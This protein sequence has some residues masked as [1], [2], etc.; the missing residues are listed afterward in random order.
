MA[1]IS[2]NTVTSRSRKENSELSETPGEV[3]ERPNALAWKAR[4]R[5]KRSVGSNPTLSEG[6][7]L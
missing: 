6:R 3:A 5:Q 7:F 2:I 1:G 4:E